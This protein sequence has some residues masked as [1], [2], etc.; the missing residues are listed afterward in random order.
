MKENYELDI[1]EKNENLKYIHVNIIFSSNS[2]MEVLE[3]ILSRSSFHFK[4][5]N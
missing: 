3:D 5:L 4:N 1:V 2:E